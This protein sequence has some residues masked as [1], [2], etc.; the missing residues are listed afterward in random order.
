[1]RPGSNA[2]LYYKDQLLIMLWTQLYEPK[3]STCAMNVLHYSMLQFIPMHFRTQHT[4]S[5]AAPG[6]PKQG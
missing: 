5:M 4:S 3:S 1:M 6:A 2:T